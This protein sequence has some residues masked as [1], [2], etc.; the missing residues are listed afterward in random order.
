M[1][2]FK[3]GISYLGR[4]IS[5][6]GYIADPK[7]IIAV[8]S[9]L[10]KKPSSI[11]ELRSILGLVGYFRRS[12]PNFS[13]TASPLY[14]IPTDTQHKQRH[15]KES[16]DWNDNHQTALDKLLRHLVTRPIL[17][18]PDYDQPFILN[19]DASRLGLGCSLF[20]MHKGKLNSTWVWKSH[21]GRCRK[22]IPQLQ[23]GILSPEVGSVSISEIIYFMYHILMFTQIII[24]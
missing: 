22:K 5:S 10:K 13:Q 6:A 7:N 4:I 18:Y 21:I 20:Q 19:T 8:S 15:S 23:V 2:L 12:I 11:T 3:R 9:K 24:R 16:I 17:A 14:Q 1:S